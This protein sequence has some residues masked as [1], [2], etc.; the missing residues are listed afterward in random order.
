VRRAPLVALLLCC[1]LPLAGC[2]GG[3]GNDDS[4]PRNRGGAARNVDPVPKESIDD[5]VDRIRGASTASDCEAVKGLL[6]STYGEPS[7]AACDAVKT[8]IDGFRD[9]RGATYKTGAAI[10]YDTLSGQRRLMVLALDG[11]GTYRV[12]FIVDVP[13][14]AVGTPKSGAFDGNAAAVVRA[15]QSGNC[16]AFLR[17]AA[18]TV[19]LGVGPDEEVCRRVSDVPFRRELVSNRGARPVPLGGN[20]NVAFYKLRTRPDAY[21]TLVM[22]AERQRGGLPRYVLVNAWPVD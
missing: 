9:P 12:A 19:G 7:E 4:D 13:R 20:A 5:V 17:L 21:Y 3:D 18:R 11:D 2:G 1:L 14:A 10:D 22:L 16:T 6:H 15:L 8:Q